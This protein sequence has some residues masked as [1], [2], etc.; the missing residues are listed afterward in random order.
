VKITV[1]DNI[2]AALAALLFFAIPAQADEIEPAPQA[3]PARRAEPEPVPEPQP[4]PDVVSE[5]EEEF[6]EPAWIPSFEIA[7]D[8][9]DYDTTS[10]V[11]SSVGQSGANSKSPDNFMFRLGGGLMSPVLGQLPGNPRLFGR[12]GARLVARPNVETLEIGG[13]GAPE[14][15][16]QSFY[17]DLAT[18]IGKECQDPTDPDFPCPTAE[19]EDFD[20]QGSDIRAT[21]SQP[22]WYAGVGIAFTIP[23][24]IDG[25]LRIKPS[26]EYNG[27]HI[28]MR[29]RV[30]S[31]TEPQPDVFLVH[32]S[33]ATDSTTDHFLGPGLELE[34]V[35]GRSTRP[36]AF[37]IYA[38][39]RFLWLVS[40]RTL[41]FAGPTTDPNGNRTGTT[42]YTVERD[43]LNIRF[44]AGMRLSWTGLG[45]K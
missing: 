3:E 16:I 26:V 7:F 11:D 6:S 28:E 37:S 18:E 32:R 13:I 10:S 35:L 17:D 19:P 9:G 36:L 21:F 43:S 2:F 14:D 23:L 4:V 45:R 42:T 30:T 34:F 29:G 20:G 40:D 39:S 12:A 24:P 8:A 5:E 1:L 27:E 31:V 38:D 44:G 33:L 15:D 25:A 41:S 22:S